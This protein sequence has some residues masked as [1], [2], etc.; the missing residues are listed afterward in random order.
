M[1]QLMFWRRL[2]LLLFYLFV[3][4]GG[5]YAGHAL[6]D[7]MAF[8]LQPQNEAKIHLAIMT[9]IVAYVIASAVPFVPGAEIGFG[10]LMVFGAKIAFLVYVGM[11]AALLLSFMV[12]RFVPAERVAA[13][14]DYLGLARAHDLVL[15]LAPMDAAA[16]LQFL[17]ARAPSR[18][19][20]V[21][22]RYRY[23]ALILLFNIPGNSVI[24]G[25]G[26]IAFTAGLCGLYS[27]PGYVIAV[28]IAVAPVP[29]FFVVSSHFS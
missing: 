25:G 13:A 2:K 29:L 9:S 10:L 14:F 12:G 6:I 5:W 8:D 23:L 7:L 11:V 20:P 17:S 16:R 27:I 15:Q 18:W 4:V 19:L 28:L 22:L 24:G 26:G 1:V 21:L 3:L